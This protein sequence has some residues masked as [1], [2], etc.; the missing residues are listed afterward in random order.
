[1]NSFQPHENFTI[2]LDTNAIG[3]E[4]G[5]NWLNDSKFNHFKY[6]VIGTKVMITNNIIF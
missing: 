2:T 4:N 6:I 1:M 5:K 3:V